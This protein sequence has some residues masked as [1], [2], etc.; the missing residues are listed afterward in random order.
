MIKFKTEKI[1]INVFGNEIEQQ[2]RDGTNTV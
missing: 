1:F 2:E